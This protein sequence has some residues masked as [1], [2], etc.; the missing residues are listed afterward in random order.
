ML[1]LFLSAGLLAGDLR[2]LDAVKRRDGLSVEQLLK[3]KADVNAVGADSPLA[4]AVYLGERDLALK[5]LA[6]GAKVNTASEYGESPLTLAA[7]N[8]DGVLVAALLKAG[9]DAKGSRWN[10][11]T[12]LM[13]A[14]RARAACRRC[15]R[16]WRR[17]RTWRR[18]TRARGNRH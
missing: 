5:L 14:G 7:A 16:W 2:V 10:A 4:W 6:A 1:A 13:L 3:Q 12:A 15:G 9:A 17:A 8:G 18:W 11:E